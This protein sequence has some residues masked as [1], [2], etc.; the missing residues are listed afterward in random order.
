MLGAYIVAG[1]L[2]KAAGDHQVA[3]RNYER[4]LRPFIEK[5]QRVAES[6]SRSFAPRTEFGL[7][8]RNRVTE[9]MSLP[10]IGR[11]A[12]GRLLTDSLRLPATIPPEGG[13]R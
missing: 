3:F 9:L 5:K 7:F 12:L 6:F 4:I 2:K 1:E 10:F 8:V 13:T 11:F